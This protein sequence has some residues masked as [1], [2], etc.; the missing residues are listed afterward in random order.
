MEMLYGES[1][2][3]WLMRPYVEPLPDVHATGRPAP[4][5][6]DVRDRQRVNRIAGWV[7]HF[8]PG[9][10]QCLVGASSHRLAPLTGTAQ[11]RVVFLRRLKLNGSAPDAT[12][13][14]PCGINSRGDILRLYV[15]AANMTHGLVLRDGN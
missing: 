8:Q 9:A 10:N 13:T 4:W 1:I 7:A 11:H 12:G 14:S 6:R 5:N 3:Y 15:D 2:A